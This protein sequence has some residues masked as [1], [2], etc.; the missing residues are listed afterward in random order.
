MKRR[1]RVLKFIATVLSV[2]GLT[3]IAAVMSL[4]NH[5]LLNPAPAFS[6]SPG[7]SQSVVRVDDAWQ[8]VYKQIPNLPRENQYTSTETGKVDPNNTLV[9]RLIRYHIYVKGRPP[10]YR[11]DWKLTLADYLGANSLMQESQYPGYDTLKTNP[12]EGDRMAI[13][14]LNRV[15]RNALAQALTNVFSPRAS[16]AAQPN[17]NPASNV[18]SGSTRPQGTPTS[19]RLPQPKPGDARLLLP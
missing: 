18:P 11:L 2:A 4:G 3:A 15:Q 8:Q 14:R 7:F 10:G 1:N 9:R 19:P 17:P 6:Q 13:G 5:S 12:L 16:Q